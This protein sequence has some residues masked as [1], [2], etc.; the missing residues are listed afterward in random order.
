M[1]ISIF[2]LDLQTSQLFTEYN[3]FTPVTYKKKKCQTYLWLE[4]GSIKV[5]TLQNVWP[6]GH[7]LHNF[8]Q[9]SL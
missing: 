2:F 4:T 5:N 1:G 3:V 9:W 8:G 6:S 7:L